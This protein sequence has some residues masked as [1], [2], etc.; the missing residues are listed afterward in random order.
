MEGI[1]D[2]PFSER[3]LDDLDV[4]TV[5]F[6]QEDGNGIGVHRRELPSL[7]RIRSHYLG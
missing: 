1:R 4:G 2:A 3:P 6:D 5:V 7:K